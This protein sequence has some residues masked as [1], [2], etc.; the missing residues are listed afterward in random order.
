MVGNEMMCEA[1]R[2]LTPEQAAD[3]LSSLSIKHYEHRQR[4][5]YANN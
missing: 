1:Q 2:N 4:E 5:N 3:K